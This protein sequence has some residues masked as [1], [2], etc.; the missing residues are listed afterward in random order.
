M[1]K[2]CL[3]YLCNPQSKAVKKMDHSSFSLLSQVFAFIGTFD[4]GL[5]VL[6]L[7]LPMVAVFVMLPLVC[8]AEVAP[9]LISLHNAWWVVLGEVR[10]GFSTRYMPEGMMLLANRSRSCFLCPHC[11]HSFFVSLWWWHHKGQ[12]SHNPLTQHFWRLGEDWNAMNG[13]ASKDRP[14]PRFF[15][16]IRARLWFSFLVT[17]GLSL[18]LT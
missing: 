10:F 11:Q 13:N 1:S 14:T 5:R 16:W 8:Q 6:L 15:L 4:Q 17:C 12:D 18:L 3:A 7:S 2:L 9:F